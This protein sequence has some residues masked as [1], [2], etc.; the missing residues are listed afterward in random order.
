MLS[1][2]PHPHLVV[3]ADLGPVHLKVAALLGGRLGKVSTY[4]ICEL[5]QGSG[6]ER[7]PN[8]VPGIIRALR[9]A[10]PPGERV[11]LVGLGVAARADGHGCVSGPRPS[12]LPEGAR[13][14]ESIEEGLHAPTLIDSSASLA[15]L[16]EARQGA[17]RGHRDVVLLQLGTAISMGIVSDGRVVRGAH[18]AAGE[19]GRILLPAHRGVTGRD[20]DARVPR[21][22]A[23]VTDAPTGYVRLD[24]VVGG[25]GLTKIFTDGSRPLELRPEVADRRGKAAARQA[26][27]GWAL[28]VADVASL[29]DPD[30]VVLGGSIIASAPGLLEPL[31]RRVAELIP[32]DGIVP[33]PGIRL[34]RLGPR[35]SLIGAAIAA[36]GALHTGN[37]RSFG[38][39]RNGAGHPQGR[40]VLGGIGA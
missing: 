5:D 9:A 23:A 21:I 14:R 31:R 34:G 39:H 4:R 16:G 22:G 40:A 37:L 11:D 28:L 19:V 8:I 12:G 36:R 6:G 32:P 26:I 25:D 13:L 3:V 29:V 2:R 30:V 33:A 27:E 15:A 38:N 1:R 20:A 10:V 18:G 17:G 7:A 35:A 24:E